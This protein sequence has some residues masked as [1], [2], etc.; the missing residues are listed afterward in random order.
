MLH[1]RCGIDG[2]MKM[3]DFGQYTE[4]EVYERLKPHKGVCSRCGESKSR[5]TFAGI[6]ED[7]LEKQ[8]KGRI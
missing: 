1:F 3:P 5:I 8:Y 2:G 7:C 6:C 4:E